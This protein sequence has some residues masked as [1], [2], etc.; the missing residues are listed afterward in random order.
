MFNLLVERSR[1]KKEQR[2]RDRESQFY[3]GKDNNNRKKNE[4][5][6]R[7]ECEWHFPLLVRANNKRLRLLFSIFFPQAP[8]LMFNYAP[9][10]LHLQLRET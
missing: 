4:R 1:E 7:I 2:E 10:H 8:V 5:E 3:V 9:Q 6:N